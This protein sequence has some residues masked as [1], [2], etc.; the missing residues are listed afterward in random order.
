MASAA[1]ARFLVLVWERRCRS[2][3]MNGNEGNCMVFSRIR[4]GGTLPVGVLQI[5]CP[6]ALPYASSN[7]LQ[8]VN[9]MP[10]PDLPSD[11]LQILDF[12]FGSPL[13]QDWPD[14]D[15]NSLWFGGG[16]VL[17]ARIRTNFGA[18]LEQAL[19]RG[20]REWE[21]PVQARLALILLLDQFSRNVYRGTAQAFA[22]DGRAQQ[23]VVESLDQGD[24]RRLPTVGRVFLYM[25]L[26][27]A[28]DLS[29]QEICVNRFRALHEASTGPVQTALEGNLRAAIE[30]RD[31]VARFGRFPHRNAALGRTDTAQEK[32]FL[33]QG[34]RF[35]Q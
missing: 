13:L 10:H 9:Q 18:L 6:R 21:Q 25:P 26:M 11:A 15:R 27:H 20:L 12:W 34:P 35:G 29:L 19:V 28:E 2:R 31:I 1:A 4:G 22:G 17:D 30:H 7:L 8:N 32:A 14:S 33:H 23:L 16:E 24:D 3:G 5:I